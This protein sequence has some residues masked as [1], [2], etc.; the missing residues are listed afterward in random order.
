[1]ADISCD[2]RGSGDPIV[3]VHGIGSRWQVFEPI[4]DQLAETNEVIA[5]DLP[6]FGASPSM[7]RVEPGPRGY[8]AWLTGWL[9]RNGIRRPHLVGNSMGGGIA[10]ELGR[11]GVASSVTAF[12]PV[13]FWGTPGLRWTQGLITAM[14]SA[15]Q[16]AGPALGKVVEVP[17]GRVALLAPFFG[18]PAKLLPETA[19][20]D[21]AALA[22]ASAYRAARHDFANYRLGADED[23]G[24]LHNIPITIAWGTRDV[25]LLHRTQSARAREVLP[26]ARH[27][28]IPRAGHL[29][30][31]DDPRLCAQIV[32]DTIAK[33][34]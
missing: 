28:D 10:L 11:H 5:I 7:G 15:S 20:A 30:F 21:M 2:R 26:F 13:G 3:L 9:K 23:F 12:S 25:V 17:V 16:V 29:P 19:R 4:L 1:M 27:L 32:L 22:G 33:E 6:G 18:Q 24:A 8:A 14:R 34:A 31:N